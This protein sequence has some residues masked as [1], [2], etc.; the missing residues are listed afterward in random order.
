MILGQ[1]P[2]GNPGTNGAGFVP[3]ATAQTEGTAPATFAV[4]TLAPNSAWAG[5]IHVVG[6]ASVVTPATASVWTA[7]LGGFPTTGSINVG[8]ANLTFPS[9]DYADANA[10]LAGIAAQPGMAS[11]VPGQGILTFTAQ[12]GANVTTLANMYL[13][14]SPVALVEDP[15][16]TDAVS[17]PVFIAIDL[18]GVVA[19]CDADGNVTTA[20]AEVFPTTLGGSALV[21]ATAVQTTGTGGALNVIATGVEAVTVDWSAFAGGQ[22]VFTAL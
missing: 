14:S 17:V 19:A 10:W 4:I 11:A 16:G 3:I 9:G 7:T 22:V 12:P 1:G 2:Q 18:L 8:N 6:K 15:V 20:T 5:D 13:D 21:G